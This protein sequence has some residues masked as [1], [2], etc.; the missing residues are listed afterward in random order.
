M[1]ILKII[2]RSDLQI[3]VWDINEP[4]SQLKQLSKIEY[5][6]K[7]GKEE[8]TKEF[9]SCRLLLNELMPN[10]SIH[11]NKYGAPE[12]NTDYFISISHSHNISAIIISKNRVGLDIEKMS[13]KPLKLSSKFILHDRH[14][15]LS[16]E[17]ATLIWCCKEAIY[18]WQQ[19]GGINF[20]SDINIL[21]FKVK[22]HGKIIAEFRN[23]HL[24]LY[25]E[26]VN[27]YYL[28]YICK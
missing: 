10:A 15:P 6:P 20:I 25:Y 1:P 21:P 9:L 17:K 3:G 26:K 24:T 16:Q 23:D 12:I 2:K 14:K 18:K 7:F 5:L 19:S 13:D 28:V 11:Y 22:M 8:R 4:V 27:T